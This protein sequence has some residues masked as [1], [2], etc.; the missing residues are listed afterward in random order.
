VVRAARA[1]VDNHSSS[2]EVDAV[3]VPQTNVTTVTVSGP[4]GD[5]AMTLAAAVMSE[6]ERSFEVLYP[7]YNI[8]VVDQPDEP[9]QT[10]PNPKLGM[11]LGALVGAVLAT[12]AVILVGPDTGRGAP[13]VRDAGTHPLRAGLARWL[14]RISESSSGDSSS[15]DGA[16]TGA[17]H[18]LVTPGF[19]TAGLDM[20]DDDPFLD[21]AEA[22]IEEPDQLHEEWA[23]AGGSD[24][25]ERPRGPDDTTHPTR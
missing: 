17:R 9:R 1:E 8:A 14:Q 15:D 24:D 6:A 11:V 23:S 10:A 4:D 16:R 18:P 20:A 21:G 7:V 25:P 5:A 12:G 19:A 13:P 3:V 2:Y 22:E